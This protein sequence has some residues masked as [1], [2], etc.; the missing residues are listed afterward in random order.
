[1]NR[2]SLSC[3]Y[4]FP[5]ESQ[6]VSLGLLRLGLRIDSPLLLFTWASSHEYSLV[7]S[8]NAESVYMGERRAGVSWCGFAQVREVVILLV[9]AVRFDT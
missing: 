9:V 8:G 2:M 7:E 1:M 4:I 6:F 3:R 5:V